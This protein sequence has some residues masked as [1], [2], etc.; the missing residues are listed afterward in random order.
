MGQSSDDSPRPEQANLSTPQGESLV[1]AA[2]AAANG[3]GPEHTELLMSRA[4]AAKAFEVSVTTFRRRFEG[5]LLAP[6]VGPDG[7]HYFR[8]NA[9]HELVVQRRGAA[10]PETYDG[11]TASTVFRLFDEGAHP[12]EVVQRLRIHPRAVSAMHKEWVSLRGGYVV[13]GE[14][15]RQIASQP[16]MWGAFPIC[17]GERLLANL[18]ASA[19]RGACA[20]CGAAVAEVCPAC[21]S[22]M[23]VKEAERRT[24]EARG[25]KEELE[26]QK[27]FAEWER[28]FSAARRR[29]V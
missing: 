25:R 15:A 13:T 23:A 11:E 22:R 19:P 28:D 24:A 20:D 7:V 12:V 29:R 26:H 18:R 5:R 6:I 16:W 21:A 2:L 27:R 3:K 8:Q 4:E 9:V 10:A 14:V 17:D 1:A